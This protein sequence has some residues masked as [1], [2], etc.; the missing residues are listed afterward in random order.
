MLA[1]NQNLGGLVMQLMRGLAMSDKAVFDVNAQKAALQQYNSFGVADL[2]TEALQAIFAQAK[3]N[4]LVSEVQ[5]AAAVA[6]VDY[7]SSVAKFIERRAAKSKETARLYNWSLGLF[8]TWCDEH[9]L[10]PLSIGYKD[11]DDFIV[12]LKTQ[13]SVSTVR[14]IVGACGA[15]FT[16]LRR[17]TDGKIAGSPFMAS[18]E[19]PHK[20]LTRECVYP[21]QSD[22]Q[23]ILDYLKETGETKLFQIVTMMA[24]DGFRAG[25]FEYMTITDKGRA[26]FTSKGKEY[27]ARRLSQ[28]SLDALNGVRGKP[29]EGYIDEKGK[30]RDCWDSQTIRNHLKKAMT[31]LKDAGKINA[32]YSAH[33]FRHFYATELYKATKD[34]RA[35]QVALGHSNIAVTDTYLRGLGVLDD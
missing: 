19:K 35:V 22:A 11:A 4:D 32:V 27:T 23:V 1:V 12:R 28:A 18:D 3:V 14:A 33:D 20:K 9:G 34:I 7:E 21:T 5:K 25:A 6:S 13:Y 24:C 26:T 29:F 31:A 16:W 10:E 2:P 15:L 17:E 30:K 8:K